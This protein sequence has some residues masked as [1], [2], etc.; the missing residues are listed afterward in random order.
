MKY[1]FENDWYQRHCFRLSKHF[2][3]VWYQRS[4]RYDDDDDDDYDVQ[5][6]LLNISSA[7]FLVLQVQQ[8]ATKSFIGQA[9]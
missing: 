5:Q 1:R 3:N 8:N 2:E 6:A 9:T 7:T 4:H